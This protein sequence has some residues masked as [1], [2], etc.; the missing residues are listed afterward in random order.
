M[1][2]DSARFADLRHRRAAAESEFRKASARVEALTEELAART[3]KL[4]ERD[5]ET[6]EIRALRERIAG[7]KAR[8]ERQRGVWSGVTS[9]LDGE[10]RAVAERGPP[11]LVGELDDRHP[12][13]LLP[14]RIETRF[15]L[16]NDRNELRVRIFPDEVAIVSHRRGLTQAELEDAK[17]YWIKRGQ[18]R[19]QSD[20]AQA[21]VLA[22]TAVTVL[23]T[24]YGGNRARWLARETRP[25]NWEVTPAPG[26]DALDFPPIEPEPPDVATPS[27]SYVL[28]DRFV[29]MAFVGNQ[30]VHEAVGAPV[31]ASIAFGPDPQLLEGVIDR[32]LVTGKIRTD[33]ALAWLVD[34]DKAVEAGLAITVPIDAQFARTGFDR[35][36][37]LGVKYSASSTE[38]TALLERLLEDHQYSSGVGVVAQGTPTNNTAD[39]PSGLS[40]SVD[41]E[42]DTLLEE[43]DA[44][45]LPDEPDHFRKPDGQRLAEALGISTDLVRSWPRPTTADVA[46]AL[47]MNRAL[48][49]ATL[50]YFLRE[51]MK[52]TVDDAFAT[53]I[54]SFFQTFVTG[55]GLLPALRVGRQPYGV[56][57][58]SAVGL[59]S[60]DES[61]LGVRVPGFPQRLMPVLQ[62]LTT[63]FR[64]FSDG[65]VAVFR[66][67]D[68]FDALVR[69]LGLQASSVSF[70]SR[71]AVG[72]RVSWN[73]LTF[74]G[75]PEF[76]RQRWFNILQSQ[77]D[78]AL[79]ALGLTDPA[80]G[81]RKLTFVGHV[82]A[83]DGPVVDGDPAVPLSETERIRPFDGTMNYIAWLA[84]SPEAV[85]RAQEFRDKDGKPV[86]VPRALLYQ[87]LRQGLLGGLAESAAGLVARLRPQMAVQESAHALVGFDTSGVV[88]DEAAVDID[89]AAIG[90]SRAR[91]ALG[92]HLLAAVRAP[93]G[94][95]PLPPEALPL[96]GINDALLR[97]RDLPTARLERL[98]AEH[99]DIC[100]YRLDAWHSALFATRLHAMRRAEGGEQGLYLGAYGYV[101]NLRS[102]AAPIAVDPQTLP[103]S[104]RETGKPVFERVDN[105]GFVH[106]PSLAQAVTAAILR[107]GYL[108][109]AEEARREAF[110][111]N[112]SSTRVRNAMQ[113]VEGLR[114]G[115]ELGAL[116]GY[117]LER[118]LHE[119]HPG[120]EL[121]IFIWRLRER[122]P[123]ISNRLTDVPDGTAAEVIEARNV[124]DGY[125]LVE[126]IRGKT[127]PFGITGLPADGSAEATAIQAEFLR[128]QDSLDAL[129]D[130]M[131]AESVHQVVQNNADRAR[132]VLQSVIEGDLPPEPDVVATP[133]SGRVL[134][135]RVVVHLP[136]VPVH[137]PTTTP[138]SQAN[139]ALNTWL[140]SQ[141]P[142]PDDIA[143]GFR[144][145]GGPQRFLTLA[146]A[147][148]DA[149]D[150]VL[151]S[152]DTI[153]DGAGE[154]ERWL[155]DRW[156][157]AEAIGG[158][159]PTRYREPAGIPAD[160]TVVAVDPGLA[161]AGKRP[162]EAIVPQLAALRRVITTARPANALDYRPPSQGHLAD[163]INPKGWLL[164]A[165]N[166]VAETRLA[167][168][169]AQGAMDTQ[170]QSLETLINDA[171]TKAA[172]E[173]L[174]ADAASFDPADWA[175]PLPAMRS[176]LRA[177]A[178]QGLPEAVPAGAA[179]IDAEAA[180]RLYE[181][182]VQTAK[183]AKAR[184]ENAVTDLAPVPTPAPAPDPD[185]AA[186]QQRQLIDTRAQRL[187]SAAKSVLGTAFEIVPRFRLA[188]DQAPEIAACLAAPVE[189]DP[190]KLE[191]WLQSL[192]RVRPLMADLAL[193]TAWRSLSRGEETA[194]VPLQVPRNAADPWIGG[195]WT[196][197]PNQRDILSV[198][199]VE[200]PAAAG[201]PIAAL[202]VDEF[203]DT[204]PTESETTGLSFHYDR[205]NAVAPHAL[206]LAVPPRLAG[207]WQWDDLVATVLDTFDRARMRAVEPAQLATGPLFHATPATHVPF[208]TGWLLSTLLVA[209]A[210]TVVQP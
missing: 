179:G 176:T 32:D 156:R 177:L 43:V 146:A 180:R 174:L 24:R 133:R 150:A 96:L 63:D 46:E 53:I 169:T 99:M 189:T 47:A 30:K 171:A 37:V 94:F 172:Y 50:G 194:L 105:G 109:H 10:L 68:P 117:Q 84:A 4:G 57:T 78:Q 116:L 108:T 125:D 18:A 120:V 198:M 40:S 158:D 14:V 102:R 35:V 22:R 197:P 101:E 87:Y 85:I 51:F 157:A 195:R 196:T 9:E 73:A 67:D 88:P 77:R 13:L 61:R 155:T 72:D 124:V 17:A 163:P 38:T 5:E 161:P 130:L 191:A 185:D 82:D 131:M 139:A 66:G 205:P 33:P 144:L 81:L 181:Q 202:L 149:I 178:L 170:R 136:D 152:A 166:D 75:V 167:V 103:E 122:F 162:L 193:T 65:V 2:I 27:R 6:E 3:R 49:S 79:A 208:S 159:V 201:G 34:Y 160:G 145:T 209:N 71:K 134:S 135:Q 28:P 127:W 121:D 147:G 132:G 7:E 114:A 123:F 45:D 148:I 141:L 111:V 95:E 42:V 52:P 16:T 142:E 31:A 90:V 69:V 137:W 74:Q 1:P 207:G 126:H 64:T 203:T 143:I 15:Q 184:L 11:V 91:V 138:R 206:L 93:P 112:L 190:L 199:A 56:L 55:R 59:W 118:G 107:N 129:S 106:A 44:H 151:M 187:R 153:G 186:R 173:A 92:Q 70:E 12:M 104:L 154:L 165:A 19:A 76:L 39:V 48:W 200:T 89:S 80:L 113:F 58:T 60:P 8:A 168:T 29:V 25:L 115:Q 110:T 54:R 21:D 26:P 204:V 83:L 140:A 183:I 36:I 86:A 98:F 23:A 119:N 100:S 128:L 182:S 164:D 188:A 20:P 41:A 62:R 175:A 210:T 97:L 192:S